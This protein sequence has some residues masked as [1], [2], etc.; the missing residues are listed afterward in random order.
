MAGEHPEPMPATARAAPHER[1]S[2]EDLNVAPSLLGQPLARPLHRLVAVA[3][4]GLCIAA[5]GALGNVWVV[6][7]L[8]GL[9]LWQWR[10]RRQVLPPTPAWHALVLAGL[11]L[12]L[13]ALTQ[14]DEDAAPRAGLPLADATLPAPSDLGDERVAAEGAAAIGHAASA[15]HDAEL[16]RLRER[17]RAQRD[18]IEALRSPGLG[19]W[20]ARIRH[21]LDEL[22]QGWLWSLLYFTLLPAGWLGG[23][24]G[25][26]LG[27]RLVGLQVAELTGKPMTPLRNLR[28][29]GGYAAGMATGGLG[30]LQLL[31]DSNRQALQDKTAH[32]VVL[33][34]RRPA[35]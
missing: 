16:Q 29:Y 31:W 27:K 2:A 19:A 24:P 35:A 23:R 33:D 34:L 13:G 12:G 1:V 3:I 32:T 21:W 9:L 17:I 5:F 26:T 30:L 25:Q 28:R 18:E 6:L 4:D 20:Q 10:G 14:G 11:L 15:V 8:V 22:G 7:A